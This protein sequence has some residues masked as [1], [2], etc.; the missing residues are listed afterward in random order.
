MMELDHGVSLAA[1]RL[2]GMGKPVSLGCRVEQVR[3]GRGVLRG[4]GQ[5][6]G[7]VMK[8]GARVALGVAGG[9]F[10]G[11]TK[12]MKLA[13]MLAGVAAGRQ[14]GGPGALLGQ[15]KNLLN[16]S[17]ELLR[18]T[19]EVKGRLIDAGKGA[20]LAVATRQVEALTDRVAGRVESS[21]GN[22]ADRG[23][24]SRN[25]SHDEEDVADEEFEEARVDDEPPEDD[26][27]EP[28]DSAID[29]EDEDRSAADESS[30][31]NAAPVR[32]GRRSAGAAQATK[33]G[34]RTATRR[35]TSAATGARRTADK[36]A[37]RPARARRRNDNG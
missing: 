17:P 10:L 19:D 26:D 13:L 34:A 23:R 11:R 15:G 6:N 21:L 36:A 28:Q 9:Y 29:E 2:A 30:S 25:S 14:A 37:G 7:D 8:C 32:R 4:A 33:T 20:A 31:T 22:I 5:P 16:A 24:G 3:G 12:K 35:T 18:L 1:S 27:T